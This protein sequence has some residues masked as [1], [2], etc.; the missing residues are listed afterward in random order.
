M[1]WRNFKVSDFSRRKL[2][3]VPFVPVSHG[4]GQAGHVGQHRVIGRP[5]LYGAGVADGCGDEV[6]L[7]DEQVECGPVLLGEVWGDEPGGGAG[8]VGEAAGDCPA[9]SR[10]MAV[11]R[12]GGL[13]W[14]GS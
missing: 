6:Q 10:E 13:F 7:A 3:I 9:L 11:G 2:K 8:E 1:C 14:G 5:G 12:D 4:A